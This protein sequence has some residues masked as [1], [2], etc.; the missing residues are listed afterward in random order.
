MKQTHYKRREMKG[1][2]EGW[3]MGWIGGEGETDKGWRGKG[4]NNGRLTREGRKRRK[5]RKETMIKG[6]GGKHGTRLE[7][8]KKQTLQSWR[9]K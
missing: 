6:Q 8:K 9:R 1:R 2:E 5:E 3:N 4:R 7:R